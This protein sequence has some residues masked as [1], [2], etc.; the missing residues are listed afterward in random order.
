MGRDQGP[1]AA[2]VPAVGAASS[3][4]G[5]G[6]PVSAAVLVAAQTEIL[7]EPSLSSALH[8]VIRYARALTGAT[9]G[10]ATVVAPDGML[11]LVVSD[12]FVAHGVTAVDIVLRGSVLGSLKVSGSSNG[13]RLQ[14]TEVLQFLAATAALVIENF[15]LA[16]DL[17]RREQWVRAST[18]I[19]RTLLRR[20]NDHAL[21]DIA[22]RLKDL[23]EADVVSV[24][25]QV[26]GQE[27]MRVEVALTPEGEG[28]VGLELPS[29]ETLSLAIVESGQPVRLVD[30]DEVA[31]REVHVSDR[32]R[33]G[34]VLGLPL[35]V[36]GRPRG[37]IVVGRL[38]GRAVFTLSELEMSAAF[39]GQ[40]ALALE[41]VDTRQA[42]D[43]VARWE[44]RT[45]IARDLHD[46]VIQQLFATGLTLRSLIRPAAPELTVA[47]ERVAG[48]LDDVIGQIRTSIFALHNERATGTR[49]VVLDT[50][51]AVAVALGRSPLVRF[52]G[53]VD[54]LTPTLRHEEI[55]A[56]LGEALTNVARHARADWV[57]VTV[58]VLDGWLRIEVVDDGVGMGGATRD[59]GLANL[60]SRAAALGGRLVLESSAEVG[61]TLLWTVPLEG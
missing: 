52:S 56:V 31:S 40:A 16:A 14:N 57:K 44:D 30:A 28:A 15:R 60:R 22:R 45:R 37:A 24:V 2:A 32:I 55:R 49:S 23:A 43:R 5:Q 6:S 10:R 9:H 58:G 51:A 18:E 39:A 59:S 34:P 13:D 8:H 46:V 7:D 42:Q 26:E 36:A 12:D 25:L 50:I 4:P 33:V 21:R 41:L 53:P 61:T 27:R 29:R 1:G 35:I 17:E 47:L 19:T 3:V 48:D 38:Q 20:G 54:S 11:E